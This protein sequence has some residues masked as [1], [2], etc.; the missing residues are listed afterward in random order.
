MAE[1]HG[2]GGQDWAPEQQEVD[3]HGG[4]HEGCSLPSDWDRSGQGGGGQ[5]GSGGEAG[6]D[7]EPEDAVPEA[8][9]GRGCGS[10]QGGGHG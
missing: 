2:G 10:A 9:A 5:D 8:A 4:G 6:P 1:G 3:S 7:V